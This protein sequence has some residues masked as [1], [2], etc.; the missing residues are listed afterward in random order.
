MYVHNDTGQPWSPL[1][2]LTFSTPLTRTLRAPRTLIRV[3]LRCT[4]PASSYCGDSSVETGAQVSG[5]I[6]SG[7]MIFP[8]GL[9]FSNENGFTG[10]DG[11]SVPCSRRS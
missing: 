1:G 11:G 5:S 9:K 2:A 3:R 10:G 6:M 8:A 7:D 4:P